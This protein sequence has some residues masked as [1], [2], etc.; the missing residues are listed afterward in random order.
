MADERDPKQDAL[1]ACV[2]ESETA[3]V[4][5][6]RDTD[7]EGGKPEPFMRFEA[8]IIRLAVKRRY[9]ELRVLHTYRDEIEYG[10][11]EYD[12]PNRFEIELSHLEAAYPMLRQA[13]SPVPNGGQLVYATPPMNSA[14]HP[15]STILSIMRRYGDLQVLVKHAKEITYDGMEHDSPNRLKEEMAALEKMC[16]SLAAKR[17]RDEVTS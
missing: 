1:A 2:P 4:T 11:M 7:G 17:E 9:G 3:T 14:P 13:G 8:Q 16:P 6:T 5:L 10:G 12:P 15:N